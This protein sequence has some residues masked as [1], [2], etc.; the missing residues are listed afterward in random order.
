MK[1][2]D[3]LQLSDTNKNMLV[4]ES[5]A[6]DPYE[7]IP[8]YLTDMNLCMELA[9]GYV[10]MHIEKIAGF[11]TAEVGKVGSPVFWAMGRTPQLAIIISVLKAVGF[12][13]D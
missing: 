8:N 9:E 2:K 7:N 1:T 13:E 6:D 4:A 10:L 5:F 11:W 12:L 3:F